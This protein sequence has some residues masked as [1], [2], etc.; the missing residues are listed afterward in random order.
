MKSPINIDK[1]TDIQLEFTPTPTKPLKT[2]GA[3]S[4]G[5]IVIKD[6]LRPIIQGVHIDNG[7]YIATDA[8]QLVVI[9]KTESD[10]DLI[11]KFRDAVIKA[12]TKLLGLKAGLNMRMKK[13]RNLKKM[14]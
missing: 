6:D 12:H 14:G 1:E 7:Q 10:N 5:G 13:L 11:N 3:E 8:N 9:N 4:L 2:S